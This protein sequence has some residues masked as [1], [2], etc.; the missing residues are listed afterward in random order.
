ML[1]KKQENL[2][3]HNH[4]LRVMMFQIQESCKERKCGCKDHE[5][6]KTRRG[7]MRK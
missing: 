6:Q 1:R 5:N 4:V 7:N 2:K 3:Y